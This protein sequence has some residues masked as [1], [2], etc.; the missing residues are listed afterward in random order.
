MPARGHVHENADLEA[1]SSSSSN[2]FDK[3]MYDLPV[4]D[5]DDGLYTDVDL[6]DDDDDQH[7][8]ED[9]GIDAQ[10]ILINPSAA[11]AA[12]SK[13]KS[14]HEAYHDDDDDDRPPSCLSR[15]CVRFLA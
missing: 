12:K 8:Q 11:A 6:N 7:S 2:H 5:T 1:P 13:T 3:D 9:A 10:L 15:L 4:Y 14:H